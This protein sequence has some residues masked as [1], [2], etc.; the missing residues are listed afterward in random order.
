ML[1]VRTFTLLLAKEE[2][3]GGGKPPGVMVVRECGR[4]DRTP[5]SAN[6]LIGTGPFAAWMRSLRFFCQPARNVLVQNARNE[7]LVREPFVQGT[8]LDRL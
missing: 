4:A 2:G 7:G 5:G 3:R 6:L 1:H 8:L